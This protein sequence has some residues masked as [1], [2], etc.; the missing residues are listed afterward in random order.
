MLSLDHRILVP[1]HWLFLNMAKSKPPRCYS[2]WALSSP[3]PMWELV[4]CIDFHYSASCR[5]FCADII[6]SSSQ[7]K[8]ALLVFVSALGKCCASKLRPWPFFIFILRQSLIT[9]LWLS[10][11]LWPSGLFPG[12]QDHR[13][14]LL[15]LAPRVPA[16]K[17]GSGE[18][19]EMYKLSSGF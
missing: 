12:S 2:V 14:R 9:L 3:F 8:D 5:P 11:N 13:T 16:S 7:L 15:D 17:A 10:L 18:T 6:E 1:F 4:I 19:W